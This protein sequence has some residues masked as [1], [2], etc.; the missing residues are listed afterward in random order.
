MSGWN[1][2]MH[3]KFSVIG[4]VRQV[5]A[6]TVEFQDSIYQRKKG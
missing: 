5:R 1:F 6:D 2:I 4:R 3:F